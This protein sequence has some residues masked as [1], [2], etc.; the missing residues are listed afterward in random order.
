M[1]RRPL[2][3]MMDPIEGT[4]RMGGNSHSGT[5]PTTILI[6][7]DMPENIGV[8]GELLRD[9]GYDVRAANSGAIALRYALLQPQPSLILLDIMMPEMDGHEV[10]RQLKEGALTRNIPVIFLTALDDPHSLARGLSEGAADYIPKPIQPEVVLARVA[11]Q[12]EVYRAR[13]WLRNQNA[14][15]EAEVDRRLAEARRIQD[16]AERTEAKLNHQRELI[17][18]SA[19]EGIFG[20]DADGVI[21]FAN[22]AA[23]ALLGYDPGGLAGRSDREL[24]HDQDADSGLRQGDRLPTHGG[25]GRGMAIRSR[26]EVFRRKDG[27]SITL[28]FTSTPVFEEGGVAGAVVTLQDISERKRYMAQLERKSNYDD[29]TGLPNRNLLNDRLQRSIEQPRDGDM[30]LAVMVLNLDRFKSLNDSLGHSAGD[31]VLQIVAKRLGMLTRKGDTLARLDGDEFVL[32]AEAPE[33]ELATL[34]AQPILD[35]LAPHFSFADRE[36]FLSGSIGIA[37]FPKDGEDSD[38]LVRNATAAML[39]A[40][41]AGGNRMNFYAPEMNAR[42]LQ[43]LDMENGLRRALDTNELVVHYQPQLSLRTGE[44]IGAEALVRWQH[45]EKGLIMPGQFIALAEECGLIL[46]L[47]EW[48]LRTA[49]AQNKA[50]QD[51]GLP[52][53]TVAVNMSARQFAAQDVVK[54][55]AATLAETGLNP[56]YLE[57]ELTESAVMADADAFIKTT[58]QLKG[59][60]ITLSIDD[61]G[62]GFSSLS[63]LKRF[64][65]DRLKVDQSFVRDVTQDTNSAAIALA[66]ISLAHSLK[67]SAIAEGVE[68]EAQLNYLRRH[69]CDEM[70]GYYF[71][72]P[73][74]AGEFEA[75]LRERRR[76]VLPMADQVPSRT[77]L[78]IDD[79]PAILSSLK[80][81]LRRE[82][83]TILTAESGTA[84]LDLLASTDV[85]VVISDARMPE[86]SGGEFLGRVR[87][88][89]PD[90]LRIMLSGYTDLKAVTTAVNS[91]ELFSFLTKPWDDAELIETVRDAFRHHERRIRLH[92]PEPAGSPNSTNC[93]TD[94]KAPGDDR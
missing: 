51:A 67:L 45:P 88:M 17:L 74:A 8:L 71:S 53:I 79:E 94:P 54:L 35:R 48:V 27:T 26:E 31:H 68:T 4:M 56:A 86:M 41:A 3:E 33:A 80:R 19:A 38:T 10:L 6:V 29:L 89:Y 23:E 63:Y 75:M 50:W 9:A 49:C 76:L 85:G 21:N 1:P 65:I 72:R 36:F 77:L 73:V 15:L 34:L 69:N 64:A 87:E 66:I 24:F 62:T 58:E 78:L 55:A 84:G 11:T 12:L 32:V 30:Q 42:S 37:L 40:K 18:S 90:I 60:S 59:L 7:D 13:E 47:G 61:F 70:Q 52:P 20:M 91:G 81:L 83:Y 43:R 28:E 44:I 16:E 14:F 92:R 57:L 22:P 5:L 39:R 46:P 93:N 2:H 82:G 25:N